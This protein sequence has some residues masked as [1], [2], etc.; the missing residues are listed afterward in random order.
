MRVDAEIQRLEGA[1][2]LG[3]EALN[4]R[5]HRRG[6]LIREG[7]NSRTIRIRLEPFTLVA[8]TTKEAELPEAFRMR[9]THIEQLE[10][11]AED[12]IVK[13]A[14]RA[15]RKVEMQLRAEAARDIA[16]RSRGTPREAIR[17]LKR[18]RDA[19]Q[20]AKTTESRR[21]RSPGRRWSSPGPTSRSGS[22]GS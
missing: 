9:F 21:R 12:E 3:D 8:A 7:A 5:N 19:A 13:V 4:A 18:A 17:L 15:A 16:R 10:S 2:R 20:E 11:Y 1:V 22:R 14:T 6:A